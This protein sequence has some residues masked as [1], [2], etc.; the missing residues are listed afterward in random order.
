MYCPLVVALRCEPMMHRSSTGTD[1]TTVDSDTTL[2]LSVA[3]RVRATPHWL[4]TYA[5]TYAIGMVWLAVTI[6]LMGESPSLA[7]T[8]TNGLLLILPPVFTGLCVLLL[9]RTGPLRS[10]AWQVPLLI[11]IASVIGLISTVLLTPA[12]VVMF[13][14]GVGR[15]PH[16]AGI[17]WAV[18]LTI[19]AAPMLFS[20]VGA[21][22]TRRSGHALVLS[23]GLAL[24]VLTLI[25]ALTPGGALSSALRPLQAEITTITVSWWL[26]FYA[27]AVAYARR[28]EMA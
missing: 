15:N 6:A 27:A 23:V 12:L 16:I 5:I 1:V 8:D 25:M 9:D 7:L 10:L 4:D 26:P 13:R 17:I 21:L 11:S 22:R 28:M 19:V 3:D 24:A 20:L 18:P 2:A 14:E